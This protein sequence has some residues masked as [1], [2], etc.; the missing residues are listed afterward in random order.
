MTK[1]LGLAEKEFKVVIIIGLNVV[2]K[3][4]S[5]HTVNKKIGSLSIE[6]GNYLKEAK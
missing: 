4:K 6:N 2:K 5:W 3:R 1:M